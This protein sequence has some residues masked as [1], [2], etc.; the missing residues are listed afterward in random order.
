MA[1]IL[2]LEKV[3][4]HIEA[5]LRWLDIVETR[6]DDVKNQPLPEPE[7]RRRGR[8]KKDRALANL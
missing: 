5:D 7:I 1:Q 8:P 6:I 2:L 4:M 3:T